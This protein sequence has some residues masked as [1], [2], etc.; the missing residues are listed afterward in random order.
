[1]YAKRK[2]DIDFGTHCDYAAASWIAVRDL[3]GHNRALGAIVRSFVSLALNIK[4]CT[5]VQTF[6]SRSK[7]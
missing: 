3:V 6:R 4:C 1:M 2:F 5:G 7:F